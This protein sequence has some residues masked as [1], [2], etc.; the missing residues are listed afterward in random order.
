MTALDYVL[1]GIV[2]FFVLMGLINGFISS[3]ISILTL[4]RGV[5]LAFKYGNLL[6]T[7]LPLSKTAGEIVAFIG[8][9]IISIIIGKIA[10]YILKKLIFGS[11]KI[12]DRLLGALLGFA[13]GFFVSF[14]IVYILVVFASGK[15]TL[16]ENSFS[17]FVWEGGRK[18]INLVKSDQI[19]EYN[20]KQ[21]ERQT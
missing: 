19:K 3:I 8:I 1:I 18:I 14:F 16:K 10:A 12:F 21:L 6:A 9:I 2:S 11:L 13:E 7:T 5:F 4:I 17:Y 20:G 15:I